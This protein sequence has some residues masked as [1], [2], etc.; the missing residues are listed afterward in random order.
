MRRVSVAGV[1]NESM[2]RLLRMII[3][4]SSLAACGDG[5][6]LIIF[7]SGTVASTPRC[8]AGGGEFD[9]RDE[10]GLVVLVV[11]DADTRIILVSG[12]FGN[13]RDLVAD[14]A[15]EVSGIDAGGRINAREVRVTNTE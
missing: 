4:S 14:D 11:I 9:L 2:R 5:S 15:V 6:L 8:D 1:H 12:Q 13:C 10:G 7:N 3:L